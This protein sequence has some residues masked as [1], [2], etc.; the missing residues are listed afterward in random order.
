MKHDN[1]TKQIENRLKKTYSIQTKV[2]KS[3]KEF[4][5]FRNNHTLE[6]L[7]KFNIYVIDKKIKLKK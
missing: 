4:K 7:K 2:F 3:Y 6:F 5:K 1:E